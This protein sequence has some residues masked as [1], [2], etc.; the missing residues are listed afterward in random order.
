MIASKHLINLLGILGINT[1]PA[2]NEKEAKEALALAVGKEEPALI[3]ITENLAEKLQTE[4]DQLNQ[5][6]DINIVSI[7][8]QRGGSGV[9]SS[10]IQKLVRNAVGAEVIARK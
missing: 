2:E 1:F 4:I 7:P 10:K 6:P 8:D 3:F 9:L 5:K